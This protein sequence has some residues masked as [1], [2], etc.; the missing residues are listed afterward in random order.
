MA[1]FKRKCPSLVGRRKMFRFKGV[2]F[3]GKCHEAASSRCS[4]LPAQPQPCTG[5]VQ[6]CIVMAH[7]LQDVLVSQNGRQFVDFARFHETLP[8]D[9][10]LPPQ[11]LQGTHCSSTR[12]S[13]MHLFQLSVLTNPHLQFSKLF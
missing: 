10:K 6:Y 13:I 2:G 9:E 3:K 4:G 1:N 5:T 8:I 11:T 12:V 7:C